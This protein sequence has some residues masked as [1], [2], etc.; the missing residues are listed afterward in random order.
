MDAFNTNAA[1]S[2]PAA[3]GADTG[4]DAS[5]AAFDA[6]FDRDLTELAELSVFAPPPSGIYL[7]ECSVKFKP[8]SAKKPAVEASFKIVNCLQQADA[9][10][11][12]AKEGQE[13]STSFV[14]VTKDNT[15]NEVGEGS[16]RAFLEPF[17]AHLGT[18]NIK[19]LVDGRI[20]KMAIT[21]TV[22]RRPQKDDPDRYN[23]RIKDINIS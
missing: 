7:L 20:D 19:Q 21:A 15:R 16:M 8:T 22:L 6:M 4:L 14:L 18:T 9:S 3:L 2:N 12:P 1:N 11:P 5:L 17:A 23:V 13:F 10:E